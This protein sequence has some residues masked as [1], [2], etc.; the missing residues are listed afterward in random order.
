MGN[1][2]TSRN[3]V[4]RPAHTRPLMRSISLA[5]C[6]QV[7]A[8]Y[9][10]HSKFCELPQEEAVTRT[11]KI[12]IIL[13]G[14]GFRGHRRV[15]NPKGP[16]GHVDDYRHVNEKHNNTAYAHPPRELEYFERE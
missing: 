10:A 1:H 9:A 11:A 6:P 12:S 5:T 8:L 13:L 2:S 16:L 4:H 14:S 7:A 3:S 15:V